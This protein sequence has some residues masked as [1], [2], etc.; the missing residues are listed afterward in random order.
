MKNTQSIN[1][2]KS[3]DLTFGEAIKYYNSS[4]DKGFKELL[5]QNFGKDFWKPKEI[6]NVVYDL[7]TLIEKLGYN[8]LIYPNPNNSFERYINACSVL[9]KVA[10]VYNEGIKLDWYNTDQCKYIPYKW[11][12]Y[13]DG[14]SV[15]FDS[16]YVY[17]YCSTFLYY[18]SENLAKQSYNNFKEYWED[19][20]SHQ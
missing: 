3:L 17:F 6:Q 16:W 4:S 12:S 19:F 8:P 14:W 9:A 10:E 13:V 11:F 5:E 15:V 7:N 1:N 20:W 18:K 2:T